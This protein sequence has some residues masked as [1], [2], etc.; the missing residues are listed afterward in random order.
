MDFWASLEHGL[1]YKKAIK[2][3]ELEER[4]LKL[5]KTIEAAEQEMMALRNDIEK[6]TT[7]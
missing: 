1:T 5:S 2:N 4:L 3:P 6:V 7:E